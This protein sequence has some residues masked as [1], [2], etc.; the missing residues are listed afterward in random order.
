M[1]GNDLSSRSRTLNGGRWRLTRFCSRCSASTSEPVTIVST[2]AIRSTSWSIPARVSLAPGLEVLAH[3]RAQR[4]RLADVEHLVALAAEEVDAGARRQPFQLPVDAAR[5]PRG[6]GILGPMSE[7]P[8]RGQ[9]LAYTFFR[10]QPEWRRLPGGRARGRQGRVR[11]GDRRV[12]AALRDAQRVLDDGRPARDAT[13]S[14][15]RS[16]SATRTSAS[17]ARR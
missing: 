14:S 2:S 17:S 10:V 5:W 4:L 9:Y 11:R 16:R 1:Y 15:G 7:Q 12:R 8:D 6:Q 3:A 13:S